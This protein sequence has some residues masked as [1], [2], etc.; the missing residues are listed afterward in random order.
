[1]MNFLSKQKSVHP[2]SLL[3]LFYS[4]SSKKS[5]YGGGVS[6][7]IILN[8]VSIITKVVDVAAVSLGKTPFYQ[9]LGVTHFNTATTPPTTYVADSTCTSNATSTK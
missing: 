3:S 5:T 4:R 1:M 8:N 9:D 6:S 2:F 7:R